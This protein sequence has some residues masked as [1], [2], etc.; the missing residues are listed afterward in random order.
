MAEML[1]M[2]K[3]KSDH[4]SAPRPRPSPFRRILQ[5][6]LVSGLLML[7]LGGAGAYFV[8]LQLERPGNRPADVIVAIPRGAS[9][10]AVAERLERQGLV[11]SRWLVMA[12]IARQ[13]LRGRQ[14]HVQ[15]GEFRIPATASVREIVEILQ[16]GRAILYKVTIPEGFSVLQVVE[17]LNAHPHLAGEITEM[18]EEGTLLPDTYVFQRGE[19]RMNLI[20][21]MQQAQRK[22]LD[23]LWPKRAPDLPFKTRREAVILASI[24]E[25][26][27]ALPHERRRV[28]AVFINRLKKGMRLQADPTIIYGITRGKPLG[29]PIRRSEIEADHP[30]NTYRI[31]GLPP[32]PIANP[33]RESIAAVLNP[34]KTD[35]LYFVADGKGGHIFASTLKA[36]NENVRKWRRIRRQMEAEM[37]RRQADAQAANGVDDKVSPAR[38]GKNDR[39]AG[40]PP[41][42]TAAERREAGNATETVT[43]ARRDVPLPRPRPASLR[44]R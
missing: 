25:K 19:T 15:A 21:R 11:P 38:G 17:R 9:T 39:T 8:L 40:P 27:T 31:R 42:E 20:R 13:R 22:L 12:E 5:S 14:K 6:L 30:W 10:M 24:V 18:P 29:R 2:K 32:T 26:E 7:I 34:E 37:R 35:D 44:R 28:A 1:A 4:Q 3:R 16:S 33:G 23:E 36:H 41:G 43:G